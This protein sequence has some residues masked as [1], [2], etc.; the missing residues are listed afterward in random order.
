M[1]IFLLNVDPAQCARDHCDKHVVKMIVES[2]QML[3]TAHHVIGNKD[4]CKEYDLYRPTHINHP[5]NI[6]IREHSA[7]YHFLYDLFLALGD[8]YTRRYGR[9]HKTIQRLGYILVV[10]PDKIAASPNTRPIWET[11]PLCMPDYCKI[12][13]PVLSYRK[14]YINEKRHIAKWRNGCQPMWWPQR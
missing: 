5:Q 9:T 12:G 2:A 10:L 1:N 6:W 3:C 4:F 8:E 7:N 13:E 11:F 14:Y